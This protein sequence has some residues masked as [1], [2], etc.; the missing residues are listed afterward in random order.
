[1]A[2]LR[3][4][5]GSGAPGRF[6]RSAT[7]A[8]TALVA[9]AIVALSVL[10]ATFGAP[11]TPSFEVNPQQSFTDQI[12]LGWGDETFVAEPR[13]LIANAGESDAPLI[14]LPVLGEETALAAGA[15]KS[16]K[17]Q[18]AEP[19]RL[20]VTGEAAVNLTSRT[21]YRTDK[22]TGAGLATSACAVPTQEWWFAGINTESGSRPLLV[23][24]NP[25]NEDTIASLQAFTTEGAFKLT[26]VGRVV[27]KANSSRVVDLTAAVPAAISAA[28]RVQ[29][30]EG[31]VVASIHNTLIAANES[32]GRSV[33]SGQPGAANK[34]VFTGVQGTAIEPRLHVLSP[35][36]DATVT[37]TVITDEGSWVLTDADERL[38]PAG[39]VAV[40]ELKDALA[41]GAATVVVE[42]DQALVGAVSQVVEIAG[43]RDLEVQS[44]QLPVGRRAVALLPKGKMAANLH[45][46]S[47]SDTDVRVTAFAKGQQVW[48]E[49]VSVSG[50][51][52][53]APLLQNQPVPGS[54]LVIE[55]S[56]PVY[57]T[58]WLQ[59]DVGAID[60]TA[61]E[62]LF[63]L[64][65]QLVP[66]A[67][68][69]LALP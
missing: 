67:K 65:A 28:L 35:S 12:C 27:V 68:L 7:A 3:L 1:M 49:T 5:S 29:V 22:G 15:Y 63:D 42:S 30:A 26:E 45:L 40:Y 33:I 46:Y 47:E 23:L 11:A 54:F 34:L 56:G 38:Q 62:A 48:Q 6:R 43:H 8:P 14:T 4:P 10:L 32:R 21:V 53:T 13:L 61:A 36:A 20:T 16:M 2:K 66:G 31:R 19:A 39:E 69:H 18:L 24:A 9:V 37:V 60:V 55:T 57:A 64:Q 58:V 25:D 17:V 51:R 44:P 50:G 41:G 52:H 59:I